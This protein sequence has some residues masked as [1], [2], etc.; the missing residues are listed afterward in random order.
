MAHAA[1][2]LRETLP[3]FM[4]PITADVMTDPVML[5]ATGQTYERSAILEWLVGHDS[6]PMSGVD[7][8][9]D[10]RIVA[11]FALRQSIEDWKQQTD[12]ALKAL[13]HEVDAGTVTIGE[14]LVSARTKDVFRGT[15]LGKPVAVCVSKGAEGGIGSK[16]ADILA[17]LGRHPC[18]VRFIARSTNA[19]GFAMIMLELAPFGN[20]HDL[21]RDRYDDHG[22][23]HGRPLYSIMGQVVDGMEELVANNVVHKDLALRNILVFGQ[24]VRSPELIR[25][26]V[27]DFGMSSIMAKSAATSYYYSAGGPGTSR[28]RQLSSRA[29]LLTD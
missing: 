8:H 21:V 25:V 17:K 7:L 2:V 14:L 4:C 10:K 6:C 13:N 9:G 15:M 28:A 23:F 24:D 1:A 11:N 12:V 18:I 27:S 20:L 22:V 29:R 19:D 26:K 3:S 5:S 16:E